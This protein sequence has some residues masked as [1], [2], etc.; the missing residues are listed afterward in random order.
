MVVPRFESCRF[1]QLPTLSDAQKPWLM[2][3]YLIYRKAVSSGERIVFMD[4]TRLPKCVLHV[5]QGLPINGLTSSGYL[6]VIVKP[7]EPS[8]R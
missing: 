4:R 5:S 6:A 8:Q 7:A 3:A 2:G 1:V